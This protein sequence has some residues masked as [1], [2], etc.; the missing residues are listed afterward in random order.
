MWP[1]WWQWELVLTGHVERRMAQR[2]VSEVDLRGMLQ[3]A[4]GWRPSVVP[5]RFLV[6]TTH[7]GA[8]WVVIVEPDFDDRHLVV[9]TVC[10]VTR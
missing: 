4:R 3:R 9:V 2:G 8:A 5:Q 1:E 7:E 6:E 10:E